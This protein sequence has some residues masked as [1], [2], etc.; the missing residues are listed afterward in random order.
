MLFAAVIFVSSLSLSSAAAGSVS[1]SFSGVQSVKAGETYNYSYKITMADAYSFSMGIKC[2]NAVI[3]GRLKPSIPDEGTLTN[4]SQTVEGQFSVTISEN[5]KPGDTIVITAKGSYD[6]IVGGAYGGSNDLFFTYALTVIADEQPTPTPTQA[7]TQAPTAMPEP[8]AAPAPS[9]EPPPAASP[10]TEPK[11]T[12]K[13]LHS[14]S[15]AA[16]VSSPSPSPSASA[17]FTVLQ[18]SEN[19]PAPSPSETPGQWEMLG[20]Q[21]DR[22]DTGSTVNITLAA[23]DVVP[24]TTLNALKAKQATLVIDF[25]S[26]YCAID[27]KRL[28]HFLEDSSVYNVTMTLQKD[29]AV[30]DAADGH[31]IYQLHFAQAGEMPGC[32]TYSFSAYQNQPGDTIYLYCYHAL[33]G[34]AEYMQSAVVD[35]NGCVSFDIYEGQSYFVTASPIAAIIGACSCS[36]R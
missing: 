12:E 23:S 34:L 9:L 17:S 7:P 15:P 4:T 8:T 36:A 30:S 2:A 11:R 10:E 20:A 16:T 1:M 21:L 27:G 29:A 32:F 13:P 14:A 35:Q 31:D 5:A 24:A 18:I 28:G 26:Y 22:L 19:T 6:C 25:G 33:S 3:N